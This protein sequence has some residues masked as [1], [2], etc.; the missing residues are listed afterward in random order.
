MADHFIAI[1]KGKD[2]FKIS[3]L[4]FGTASTPARDIELRIADLDGQGRPMTR[5]DVLIA[6]EAFE[7]ALTSGALYT[8]FPKL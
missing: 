3:D 1:D 2:G 7:R 5:K 8:N 4:T 6:L